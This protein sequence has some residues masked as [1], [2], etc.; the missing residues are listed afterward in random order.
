MGSSEV[1]RQYEKYAWLLIAGVCG[2]H[3]LASLGLRA[4]GLV[5]SGGL[6][7]QTA[8]VVGL[9]LLGLAITVESYRSGEVWAWYTLWYLP[10]VEI[11]NFAGS[12]STPPLVFALVF[13][14]G[15]LMSYRRFFPNNP[16]A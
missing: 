8:T 6:E 7:G 11:V 16:A 13:V 3:I 2:F 14:L 1:E 5:P 15:Q 10:V 4:A 12:G 9:Y